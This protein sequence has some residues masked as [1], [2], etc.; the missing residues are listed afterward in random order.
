MSKLN[1]VSDGASSETLNQAFAFMNHSCRQHLAQRLTPWR[2]LWNKPWWIWN[3]PETQQ[4]YWTPS[5][6]EAIAVIHTPDCAGFITVFLEALHQQ[7]FSCSWWDFPISGLF[8]FLLHPPTPTPLLLAQ[9][10]NCSYGQL[11]HPWH[12]GNSAAWCPLRGR[13]RPHGTHVWSPDSRA[14]RG[15][16]AGPEHPSYS[17]AHRWSATPRP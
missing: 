7:L 3:W 9:A 17:A 4:L 10:S 6:P 16:R 1:I 14:A 8:H 15:H 12:V 11:L 13:S 5:R 2:H